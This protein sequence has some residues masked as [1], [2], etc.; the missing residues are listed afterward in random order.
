MIKALQCHRESEAKEQAEQH[1]DCVTSRRDLFMTTVINL[2]EQSHP[3]P[4][5]SLLHRHKNKKQHDDKH[6][7]LIEKAHH[8][9]LN[10]KCLASTDW[11]RHSVAKDIIPRSLGTLSGYYR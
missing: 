8:T 4:D 2:S 5:S 1:S 9:V 10:S 7:R 6:D 11:I 3:P